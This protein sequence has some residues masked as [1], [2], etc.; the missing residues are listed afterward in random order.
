MYMLPLAEGIKI[1]KNGRVITKALL[2]VIATFRTTPA[3]KT[4]IMSSAAMLEL[5][6]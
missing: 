6:L 3:F 1:D 4:E 5:M 2:F